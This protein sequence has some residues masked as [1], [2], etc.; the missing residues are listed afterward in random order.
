MAR[1]WTLSFYF[2][3]KWSTK[4]VW[5]AGSGAVSWKM[6]E[7]KARKTL[8][9]C[10][11]HHGFTRIFSILQNPA[12]RK[13]KMDF[14]L[15]KLRK[16]GGAGLR[17]QFTISTSSTS[18]KMCCFARFFQISAGIIMIKYA[19]KNCHFDWSR[20]PWAVFNWNPSHIPFY[21][22]L[23]KLKGNVSKA[24]YA[25]FWSLVN[26]SEVGVKD[27]RTAPQKIHPVEYSIPGHQKVTGG[28]TGILIPQN[29]LQLTLYPRLS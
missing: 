3:K 12:L 21:W 18:T 8:D 7:I 22:L 29:G 15:Q 28:S 4:P 14:I 24:C 11:F 6:F 13:K 20:C 9:F 17:L 16:R 25:G 23:K 19:K 5:K 2:S 10:V 26:C 27:F 1:C